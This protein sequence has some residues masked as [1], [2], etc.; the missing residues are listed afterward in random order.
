MADTNVATTVQSPATSK[1]GK[2]SAEPEPCPSF[3]RKAIVVTEFGSIVPHTFK[4][5]A[6]V[7]FAAA[8]VVDVVD[9]SQGCGAA[10]PELAMTAVQS[11]VVVAE[12]PM[13]SR[14]RSVR[15]SRRLPCL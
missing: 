10:Q 2:G 15:R 1:I 8:A 3:G 14:L 13:A 11:E 9:P 12:A 7:V 4:A 5:V 6:V